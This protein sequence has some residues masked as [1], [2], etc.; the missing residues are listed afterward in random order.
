MRSL[1]FEGRSTGEAKK[2]ERTDAFVHSDAELIKDFIK[3]CLCL[4]ALMRG[5]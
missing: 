1:R 4:A 2:R 3:L 5:S